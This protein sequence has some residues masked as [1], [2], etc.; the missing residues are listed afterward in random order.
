MHVEDFADFIVVPTLKITGL[1]SPSAANLLLGTAM[2]ESNLDY[3]EQKGSGG[4]MSFFQIE[5]ATHKD[6]YRYMSRYDN[7]KLKEVLLSCAFYTAWPPVEA[8]IHNMR[9]ACIIARLKYHMEPAK[10]PEAEDVAGLSAYYKKY[11]NT[12]KGKAELPRITA[13]FESIV[14]MKLD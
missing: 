3:L 6:I 11:Y 13:A 2:I 14:N 1:Y 7:A 4:A 5:E 10:L 8:L 12:A 9:W